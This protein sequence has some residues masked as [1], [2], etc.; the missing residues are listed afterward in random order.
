MSS[1]KPKVSVIVPVY[2][3]EKYL[4]ACLDSVLNQTLRDIEVVC[5]DDCSPDRCGE[6]LA[7]YA[8]RDDR[9]KTIRFR[10]NRLQGFARN[11]GMERA[12]GEY[13]YFLDSDDMIE[14][15]TLEELSKLSDQENLDAAFFDGK[16]TYENEELK[17]VLVPPFSLRKGKYRN[18]VATGIELLDEFLRQNEW[19]CYPQRIFWR[20]EF[21]QRNGI[22]YLE[23][24]VQEDEFFAFAGI[25]TAK[26][27]RYVRRQY[28]TLRI[29]PNSIMTSPKSPIN[30]HGYLMS[31]YYMNEFIT[32]RNLDTY[33]AETNVANMWRCAV[34]L[35]ETLKDKFN[36]EESFL[37]E[38]DKTIYRRFLRRLRLED[39]RKELYPVNSE[40]LEEIR[41]YRIAYV[42]GVGPLGRTACKA[43]ENRDVLI[44]GFLTNKPEN[45]PSVFMGRSVLEL[46]KTEMPEDS[47]VVVATSRTEW[48]EIRALLEKR[49]VRC[50]SYR[51]LSA[52]F[53][54]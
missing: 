28:F 53:L 9:V 50:M 4:P 14:P 35:Y 22:R 49:N 2:K 6:I 10:E 24:C 36:L 25:L 48:E 1:S 43:L 41:K 52:T 40:A 5:V 34:S 11:R 12:T 3:T 27:V 26:R 13:V 29:R 15:E 44:G 45:A 51:N 39:L 23:G 17:K 20:R 30:F 8:G 21:L 54:P 33:G 38:P 31:F 47:I 16:E 19:T 42:Y 37:K 46:A 7:E 18:E 32:E